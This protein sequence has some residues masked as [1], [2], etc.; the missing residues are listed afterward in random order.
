[1]GAAEVIYLNDGDPVE[2]L[3]KIT[4]GMG[5]DIA[6]ECV[7]NP[8]TPQLA[9]NL[10]CRHG[11][12]VIIGVLDKPGL[13]DFNTLMFAER[14]MV[15]NSIYIDEGRTAIDLMADGR[16]DPSPMISATLKRC[17]RRAS[18]IWS[19]LRGFGKRPPV[20]FWLGRSL[21]ILKRSFA[22][23]KEWAAGSSRT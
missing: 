3:E 12:A 6:L 5:A 8:D 16:I 1:M 19:K 7:G 9:V 18:T 4:N 22:E 11:T 15:G 2:R 23:W 13:I 14:T 10:T 20:R 21:L 17:L